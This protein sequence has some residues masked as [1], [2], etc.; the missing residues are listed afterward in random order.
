LLIE[1]I[2]VEVKKLSSIS[3]IGN[4]SSAKATANVSVTDYQGLTNAIQN[5]VF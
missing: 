4:G 1:N 5:S 2:K 3:I